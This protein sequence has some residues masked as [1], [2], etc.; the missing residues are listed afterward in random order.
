MHVDVCVHVDVD[1]HGDV[2][3]CA[4]E[5]ERDAREKRQWGKCL[6]AKRGEREK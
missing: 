6:C 3:V 1:G 2:D 4:C 5:L